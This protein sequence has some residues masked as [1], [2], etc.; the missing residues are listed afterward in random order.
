MMKND[1]LR[2]AEGERVKVYDWLRLF[3][4]IAVVIGHSGYL[5]I[6]TAYGGYHMMS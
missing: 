2:Q 1:V 6:A 3:A 4:T 5:T